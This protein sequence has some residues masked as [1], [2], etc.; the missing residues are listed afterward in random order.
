MLEHS[1]ILI[2]VVMLIKISDILQKVAALFLSE[3]IGRS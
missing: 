1:K 2:Y 3:N